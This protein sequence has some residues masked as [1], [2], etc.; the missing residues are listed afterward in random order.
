MAVKKS[1]KRSSRGKNGLVRVSVRDVLIDPNTKTP[2]L[3]LGDEKE[4]LVIPIW[5]GY[6]EAQAIIMYLKKILPPRPLTVELLQNSIEQL[7]GKVEKILIKKVSQGTFYAD[8]VLRK[9][10]GASVVLD[11]RPSDSVGLAVKAQAPIF[12][13]KD[14]VNHFKKDELENFQAMLSILRTEQEETGREDPLA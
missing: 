10:K 2:V 6:L 1:T 9:G 14:V 11:A 5:I 7:G 3:F 4:G 13:H 8:I 12:I